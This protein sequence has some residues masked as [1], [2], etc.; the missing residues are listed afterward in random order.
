MICNK[1][2]RGLY[3]V[4]KTSSSGMGPLRSPAAQEKANGELNR[5]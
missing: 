1:L 2:A 3:A 5:S 4:Y